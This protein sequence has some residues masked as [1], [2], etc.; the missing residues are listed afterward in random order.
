[1]HRFDPETG[2]SL[3]AIVEAP[4]LRFPRSFTFV[5]RG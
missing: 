3:G 1:V 5:S 2:E 4:E